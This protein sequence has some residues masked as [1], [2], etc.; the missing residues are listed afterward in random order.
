MNVDWAVAISAFLIFIGIGFASYWTLFEPDANPVQQ[1]LD[2]INEKVLSCMQ[3][4]SWSVPVSYNSSSSGI[5]VLHFDFNWPAG[6]SDSARVL[7][8]GLQ[9]SCMLQ[10]N[11]MYFEANVQ[12]GQND[13]DMV[14]AN[15]SSPLQCSS[16]IDT[17]NSI[18]ATPLAS[19]KSWK[20]SQSRISQMLGTEYT[21]FRQS[22]GIARNFQVDTGS[23]VYGPQ[24]PDKTSVYVKETNSILYETGQPVT[25]RVKVW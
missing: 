1:A 20:I 22:L 4:E 15:T 12:I 25:I 11:R 21:Q 2:P 17:T 7:D 24:P 8:S 10:G 9:L 13:F 18:H 16:I 6:T 23:G 19:E 14:F 5:A 3:V